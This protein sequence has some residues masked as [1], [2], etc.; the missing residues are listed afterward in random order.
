MGSN[1]PQISVIMLAYESGKYIRAS[2]ESILAQT[3]KDF[4]LLIIYDDSKDD[5]IKIIEEFVKKDERVK[6]IKNENRK[7]IVGAANTGL[8]YAKGKYIAR[9]DSD[10]LSL[11]DRLEKQITFMEENP[12]YGLLGGGYR[13]IDSEGKILSNSWIP[14]AVPEKIKS[15]LLFE[16][17]FAQST[18]F[19]RRTVLDI[20]GFYDENI[21]SMEDY[22]L[23]VRCSFVTKV[24]NLPD[25]LVYYRVHSD[26]DTIRKSDIRQ[27]VLSAAYKYQFDKISLSF[28]A[29]ELFLHYSIYNNNF[30]PAKEF[31][32]KEK[33]WLI[34][35]YDFNGKNG[36]YDEFFFN[37]VLSEKW[38]E[39]CYHSSVLGLWAFFEYNKFLLSK[40]GKKTINMKIKFF[41]RCILRK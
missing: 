37:E 10:D 35:L 7:G 34:K 15:I 25:I 26:S 36:K 31:I 30:I 14:S 11:P 21:L 18:I 22:N 40:I 4:E 28:T 24:W 20:T 33:L 38:F 13:Q 12:Q 16:N 41:I 2:I 5:T 8:K 23:W 9:L 39:I 3:F 29:E 17:Y 6:C 27:T 19:I 32:Q 1:I